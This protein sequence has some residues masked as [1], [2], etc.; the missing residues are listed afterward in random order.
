MVINKFNLA[1]ISA[2]VNIISFFLITYLVIDDKIKPSS[3]LS[4]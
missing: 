1:T 2:G 4:L 3:G